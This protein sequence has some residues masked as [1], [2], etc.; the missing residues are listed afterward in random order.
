[1]SRSKIVRF[2]ACSWLPVF[3][4][5]G[6]AQATTF[7]VADRLGDGLSHQHC[8][9]RLYLGHLGCQNAWAAGEH[10]LELD[11][12]PNLYLRQRLQSCHRRAAATFKT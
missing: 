9:G 12:R 10:E 3:A 6:I 2:A 8:L 1:M 5:A 7:N 4:L 11:Q